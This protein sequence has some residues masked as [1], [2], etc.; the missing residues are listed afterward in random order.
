MNRLEMPVD[1]PAAPSAPGA[2]QVMFSLLG[3]AHAL[4]DRLEQQLGQVGL[5]M[6]K[7]GVL[8]Q[9]VE[10]GTPLAL[11]D[12]AARLSCV[13]S[14][15]TQLVD[16]LES[17]GLVRRVD[18]PADRRSVL[19]AVTSVGEERQAAGARELAK[20]RE[21]FA[22]ALPGNDRVALARALAALGRP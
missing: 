16:R 3:A 11:S 14:N 9:L 5:S 19:A 10:A 13:R 18:D 4:E 20:V 7:L 6:S 21:E 22:A 1:K 15:M 17:E 12:L 2:E 8:T